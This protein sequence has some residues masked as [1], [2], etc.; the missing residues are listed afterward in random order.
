MSSNILTIYDQI[1]AT[2]ITVNGTAV[3]V[4]DADQLP[5]RVAS[6]DLPVRLL[7]PLSG[8]GAE[9]AQSSS[10]WAS[11]GGSSVRQVEWI[12]YDLLLWQ[13]ITLDV[14]VKAWAKELLAYSRQYFDMLGSLELTGA[15]RL[16]ANLTH[17]VIEYPLLSGV[18]YGG[19]RATLTIREKW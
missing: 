6:A 16:D 19:V 14:G 13:P 1:A 7:T 8:F 9:G 2:S 11:S 17:S 10:V 3:T 5:N 4:K 18:L 12:I 15:V